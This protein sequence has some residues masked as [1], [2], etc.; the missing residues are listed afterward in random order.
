[1]NYSPIAAGI[2]GVMPIVR[3]TG[4]LVSLATFQSPDAADFPDGFYS[5]NYQDVPGLVDLPCM[6]APISV[7]SFNA[8]ESKALPQITSSAARHV[9]LDGFYP[10]AVDG[11][12]EG[13]Q[14]VV[15]GQSFDV[16]GV[17]GDSQSQMTRV[18]I[19]DVTI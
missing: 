13:W 3:A 5:G 12:R 1:M 6:S 15:D 16:L 8:D 7:D 9:L 10:A 11:W 14:I 2:A 19:T 4:L 17:E 18:R